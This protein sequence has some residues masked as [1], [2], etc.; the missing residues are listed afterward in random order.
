[1]E[2]GRKI[3]QALEAATFDRV[4]G[5]GLGNAERNRPRIA[6]SVLELAEIIWRSL[7]VVERVRPSGECRSFSS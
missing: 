7:S 6:R 4:A 2:L 1:M 5:V 3:A